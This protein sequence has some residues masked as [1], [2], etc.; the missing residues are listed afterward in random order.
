MCPITSTGLI[1]LRASFLPVKWSTR[2]LEMSGV[3]PG[4]RALDDEV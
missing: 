4:G 3:L 1:N 2:G